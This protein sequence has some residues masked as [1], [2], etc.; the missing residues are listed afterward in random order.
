[1]KDKADRILDATKEL[2]E[3]MKLGLTDAE[4]RVQGGSR[5]RRQ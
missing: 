4:H 1:M 2:Y 3:V 5:E